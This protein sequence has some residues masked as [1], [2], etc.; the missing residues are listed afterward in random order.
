MNNSIRKEKKMHADVAKVVDLFVK[1]TVSDG[2]RIGNVWWRC[3]GD[4]NGCSGELHLAFDGEFD[5]WANS[6]HI[7]INRWAFNDSNIPK[8]K[9]FIETMFDLMEQMSDTITFGEDG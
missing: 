6:C 9:K 3:I 4:K 2:G 1:G 7:N 5:R 8:M